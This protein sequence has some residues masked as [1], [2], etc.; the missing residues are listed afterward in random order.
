MTLLSEDAAAPLVTSYGDIAA[1]LEALSKW[2][3]EQL[4]AHLPPTWVAQ[5]LS[6]ACIYIAWAVRN[7]E[8]RTD[9]LDKLGV[10][11]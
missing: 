6:A 7:G 2:A 9:A 8:L 11:P 4:A 3:D 10:A 1:M 5:Q